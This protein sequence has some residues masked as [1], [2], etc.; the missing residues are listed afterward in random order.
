VGD[1]R[2]EL[3]RGLFERWN[4]GIREIRPD[5]IAPDAEVKSAMTGRTYTGHDGIK[6]W[7]A[8]IDEQFDSWRL[9]IEEIEDLPGDRVLAIGQVHFRGRGSGVEFDQA[10]GWTFRFDG[11]RVAEMRNFSDHASA[12]DAA[13]ALP[14]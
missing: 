4:R 9:S 8:E 12:R 1:G 13:G 2:Q 5:E 10:I 6:E 3:I 7:M 14:S 11:E